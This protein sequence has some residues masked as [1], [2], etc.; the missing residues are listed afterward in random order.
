MTRCIQHSCR[1][2]HA[3]STYPF[4][5]RETPPLPKWLMRTLR[6]I[7]SHEGEER[8]QETVWP[9]EYCC[10]NRAADNMLDWYADIGWSLD[11]DRYFRPTREVRQTYCK[12]TAKGTTSRR[13]ARQQINKSQGKMRQGFTRQQ[14]SSSMHCLVWT[15][16]N[17]IRSSP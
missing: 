7:L 1:V 6:N 2:A 15:H 3:W 16:Y 4:V 10:H 13:C 17:N 14:F 9:G 8:W 5:R 12:I 11:L